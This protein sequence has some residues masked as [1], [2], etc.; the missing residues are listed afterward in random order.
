[1]RKLFL[2]QFISEAVNHIQGAIFREDPKCDYVV[3]YDK[4]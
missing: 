2:E 3:I 4:E 1:M